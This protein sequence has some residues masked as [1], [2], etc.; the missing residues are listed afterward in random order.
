MSTAVTGWTLQAARLYN[1]CLVALDF[2]GKDDERAEAP[3]TC[4]RWLNLWAMLLV[5]W[6]PN[7]NYLSAQTWRLA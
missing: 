6:L 4:V 2:D 1:D 5:R 7:C 3:K